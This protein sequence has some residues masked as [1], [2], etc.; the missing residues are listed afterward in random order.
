MFVFRKIACIILLGYAIMGHSQNC[1]LTLD[2]TIRDDDNSEELGFAVIKL[3]SSDKIIQSD[4]S[5]KFKLDGL[6]TGTY[7]ILIK[8]V[9]CRDS[10]FRIELNRSKKLVFKLPHSLNAL[11]DVIISTSRDKICP[12]PQHHIL[13]SGI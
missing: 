7:S 6:C 2:G 12:H 10:I 1:A 4:A 11:K 13:I 9:G 8:H 5:G 3:L